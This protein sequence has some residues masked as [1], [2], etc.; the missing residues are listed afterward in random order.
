MIR[1]LRANA[2][3]F[4]WSAIDMPR[5]DP[6]V[7][8][9]RLNVLSESQTCEAKEEMVRAASCRGCKVRG[10]EAIGFRVHQGGRVPKLDLECCNGEECEW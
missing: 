1:C 3:I 10:C 2:D 8:V 7:I 4:A 9:H 6:Q 5:V